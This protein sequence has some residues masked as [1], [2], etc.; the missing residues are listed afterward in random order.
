MH[1]AIAPRHSRHA[2]GHDADSVKHSSRGKSRALVASPEEL[3]TA[4]TAVPRDQY[5]Q[6]VGEID[7]WLPWGFDSTCGCDREDRYEVPEP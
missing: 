3:S 2:V 7:R 1:H 5:L 4:I 6:P